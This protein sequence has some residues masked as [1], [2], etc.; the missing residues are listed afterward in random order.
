MNNGKV[1]V[2]NCSII[3]N[4]DTGLQRN[5]GNLYVFN[6]II[7]SNN[8]GGTQIVGS[9]TIINSNIENGYAGTGN[10]NKSPIFRPDGTVPEPWP[11]PTPAPAAWPWPKRL[12]EYSAGIDAGDPAAAANDLCFYDATTTPWGSLGTARN[13]MGAYGGPG[14]CLWEPGSTAL[15]VQAPIGGGIVGVGDTV[16]LTVQASGIG[17]FSYVWKKDGEVVA[18]VPGHI[19]GAT[20]GTL[21]ITGATAADAGNYTV[22][23]TNA[24]GDTMISPVAPLAVDPLRV[25]V[26]VFAGVIIQAAPGTTVKVEYTND[27]SSG[28]WTQLWQGAVPTSPYTYYDADSPNHPKRFYRASEVSPP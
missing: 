7:F 17:P 20:T 27:L 2:V 9:P 24:L 8:S 1:N 18:D 16:T 22:E 14:A 10:I 23:V 4:S 6:S 12:N 3:N 11:W 25:A 26:K 21:T 19:A 5:G 15:A 28:S 13:D